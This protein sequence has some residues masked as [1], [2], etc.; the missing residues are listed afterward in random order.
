MSGVT[1]MRLLKESGATVTFSRWCNSG[2]LGAAC[3][4]HRC[5]TSR[6]LS[7]TPETEHLAHRQAIEVQQVN[8]LRRRELIAEIAGSGR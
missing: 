1:L 2:F 6:G 4:C 5:R 3:N 7:V 8:R